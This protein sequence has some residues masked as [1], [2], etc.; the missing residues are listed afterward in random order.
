MRAVNL[1][2]RHAAFWR[3]AAEA[4]SS[5]SPSSMIEM[6]TFSEPVNVTEVLGKSAAAVG[7]ILLDRLPVATPELVETDASSAPGTVDECGAQK[8]LGEEEVLED[9]QEHLGRWGSC[10]RHDLARLSRTKR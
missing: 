2:V 9:D 10:D 1:P 8:V 5:Q 7:I 4:D 6:R 3:T